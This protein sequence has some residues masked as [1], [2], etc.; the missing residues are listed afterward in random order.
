MS[1]LTDEQV[2]D[3]ADGRMEPA[4]ALEAQNHL[5]GCPACRR[6]VA[7]V[8]DSGSQATQPAD[9]Q[10][11]EMPIGRG[12]AIGR[13]LIT[14]VLGAG[15]MGAVYAGYDPE[16][17]RRVAIK[18]LH[19]RINSEDADCED[20]LRREART[21]ARLVHPNVVRIYDVGIHGQRT[22][23]A[24]ELVEGRT[25]RRWLQGEAPGINDI[26]AAF[27]AAGRGLAAAHEA[28]ILH[29]D[30]KPDNVFLSHE[31]RACVG[32]FGLSR[33]LERG[34]STDSFDGGTPGT[35][36]GSP[37]YL[38]PEVMAGLRPSA[39]SDQFSFCV[40]L[41]EALYGRRPFEGRSPFQ[42]LA[43]ARAREVHPEASK[44]VPRALRQVLLRGLDPDPAARHESM[45]ALLE[46][47]EQRPRRK[48]LLG[49]IAGAV[50]VACVLVLARPGSA[51]CSGAAAELAP[52]WSSAR[53]TALGKAFHAA[54]QDAAWTVAD[55]ALST[56]AA[57]WTA[58]HTNSC[59]ATRIE[60]HQSEEVLERRS[61]C[62][63][64]QREVVAALGDLWLKAPKELLAKAPAALTSLP[65]PATCGGDGPLNAEKLAEP[66]PEAAPRVAELRR[67][68]ATVSAQLAAGD[69]AS[70]LT[71]A[72]RV[73]ADAKKLGY[74]PLEAEALLPLGRAL[75]QHGD[76]EL[77]EHAYEDAMLAA[78][79]ARHEQVLAESLVR[80][81]RFIGLDR[82]RLEEGETLLARATPVVARLGDGKL[83]SDL[84]MG[85]GL[86]RLERGDLEGA[87]KIFTDQLPIVE[88]LVGPDAQQVGEL[89][90]NLFMVAYKL[91]RNGD[92]RTE[93]QLTLSILERALP[94][95][96]PRLTIAVMDLATVEAG[97]GNLSASHQLFDRS[98]RI[99]E[100][101]QGPEGPIVAMVLANQSEILADEGDL[102]AAHAG[103]ER[104]LRI[105]TATRGPTHPLTAH[106]EMALGLLDWQAGAVPAA[107]DHL[108]R[109]A[110][111][112]EDHFGRKNFETAEALSNYGMAKLDASDQSGLGMVLEAD[113]IVEQ[114]SSNALRRAL[115]AGH[116][117]EA[118]LDAHRTDDAAPY[119]ERM[120]RAAHDE[121]P[122]DDPRFIE[123]L[124]LM[125]RFDLARGEAAERKPELEAAVETME[126]RK[127]AWP[128][129]LVEA[130]FAL[131]QVLAKDPD[132]AARQRA[133][134]LAWAALDQ[135]GDL[136]SRQSRLAAM[137]AFT[138]G[139]TRTAR[140]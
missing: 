37:A 12:T 36:R 21:M 129:T 3:L 89:H 9:T 134:P 104:A 76:L 15:G 103:N 59:R 114:I 48:L 135:A 39:A 117:C 102:T 98:L 47:I 64:N 126:K 77:A 58:V 43:Q 7:A 42:L 20:R 30:F 111:L 24:M 25:L 108:G 119:C 106:L 46:A 107:L 136:G 123:T 62:L 40:S 74:P 81:T 139:K 27:A 52:S 116:A 53:R 38:A 130:R 55:R 85:H 72:R 8:A 140:R 125:T 17:E 1:C 132:P 79:A 87:R 34:Q 115:T 94:P 100:K 75:H 10:P 99:A 128:R 73:S 78:V 41:W 118:L 35:I 4:R 66:T 32:D 110:K 61:R 19:D 71:L 49:A 22:F 29:G 56:F 23:I 68:L 109:A 124:A 70:A 137:K 120:F 18:L 92:A 138:E 14:S 5:D 105:S 44:N 131:A 60:G 65:L 67:D 88:A 83:A 133:L 93:A 97:L 63:T 113:E 57:N 86:L 11:L 6:L 31:G 2:T 28:G 16:L 69:P 45:A 101:N 96:N 84:E 50:V 95:E 90:H 33:P 51:R 122:T 91:G 82:A 121:W 13:Y 112:R 26:M 80:L 127:G 54:G